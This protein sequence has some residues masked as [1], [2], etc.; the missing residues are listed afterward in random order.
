MG[1]EGKN[2]FIKIKNDIIRKKNINC[3]DY[4]L[5]LELM[6]LM[7][8]IIWTSPDFLTLCTVKS[9][10]FKNIILQIYD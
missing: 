4:N 7:K 8:T 6:K 2:H 9:T 10:A 5:Q 1:F 3:V